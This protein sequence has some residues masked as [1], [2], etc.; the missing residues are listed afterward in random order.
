MTKEFLSPND[1]SQPEFKPN[2]SR[3]VIANSS[4]ISA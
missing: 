4:V 1:Q 3:F 2:I